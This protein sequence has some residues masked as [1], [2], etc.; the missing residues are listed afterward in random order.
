V[1][2]G[3]TALIAS[4]NPVLTSLLAALVLGEALSWRKAIGLALG[5]GGVAYV[6]DSTLPCSARYA[7]T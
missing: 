5:V 2:S 1:S 3:V 6:V 7:P 4:A